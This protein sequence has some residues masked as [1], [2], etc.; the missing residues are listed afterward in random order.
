[1]S[2]IPKIGIAFLCF[3]LCVVGVLIV[4]TARQSP[5]PQKTN[6]MPAKNREIARRI[7]IEV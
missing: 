2:V 1:V 6:V 4:S 7:W 5:E 3:S